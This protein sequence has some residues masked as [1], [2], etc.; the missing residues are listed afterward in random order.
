MNATIRPVV[1]LAAFLALAAPLGAPAADSARIARSVDLALAQLG[2]GNALG[3]SDRPV[4]ISR[5]AS[6]RYELGA[7][8][9]TPAGATSG[10]RVLAVTPGLAA[11]RLGLKPGDTLLALNGVRFEQ[12]ARST[13]RLQHALAA[14]NGALQAQWVRDG[15]TYAARG[16]ADV[17][18]VPAYR[19]V[20]GETPVAGRCGFV[21]TRLSVPPLSKDIH[22]AVITRID[23]RSTPLLHTPNRHRLAS[24][25]HVLVVA[26]A[27]RREHLGTA[28]TRKIA[29]MHRA[30]DADAYKTLVVDIKPGMKYMIGARLLTDRLD[31]SG[32]ASN[33]YWEPVIYSERPEGCR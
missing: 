26:E 5:P 32:I 24:G 14:A 27:I 12:G 28:V 31:P 11:Q 1:A 33:S 15:R 3:R 21:S 19:L 20:V 29:Q 10:L 25:R 23:G 22:D 30:R 17:T 13:T 8:V 9:D 2:E 6:V 16:Q 7:V 4:A 18:A